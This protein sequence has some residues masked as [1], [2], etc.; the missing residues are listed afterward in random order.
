MKSRKQHLT[1][2]N[3]QIKTK[4][5]H[6]EKRKPTKSWGYWKLTPSNKKRWKKKFRKNISEAESYSRQNDIVETWA[7]LLIRYLGPFL[8]WT[9]E[10]LKQMDQRSRKL[11]TMHKALHPRDDVDI[12]TKKRRRKRTCLHWR[13]CWRIITTTTYKNM[14]ED[15]LQPPETILRTRRPTERH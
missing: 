5:E 4:I 8:K 11:M 7:V 14:E 1:E 2:R 15:W 6:L 9:R 10:E 12:C 3:N 13:Q